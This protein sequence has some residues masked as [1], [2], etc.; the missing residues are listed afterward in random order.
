ME[1]CWR[2]RKEISRC[3]EK[4]PQNNKTKQQNNQT[5][6]TTKKKKTK[7]LK[8][9]IYQQIL[10][11]FFS[12]HK[13]LETDNSLLT[14]TFRGCQAG[15]CALALMTVR[16]SSLC[17]KRQKTLL[18]E[19]NMFYTRNKKSRA[20]DPTVTMSFKHQQQWFGI[21]NWG[22]ASTR[23]SQAWYKVRTE[24]LFS[25]QERS[26]DKNWRLGN[27]STLWACVMCYLLSR[28]AEG[29]KGSMV[30]ALHW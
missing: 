11:Y 25:I 26:T 10:G 21:I 8:K 6:S 27:L 9:L 22:K 2:G 23:N 5:H 30:D 17:E 12:Q 20:R 24:K 1:K 16:T 13:A 15:H 29:G 28:W 14:Y 18:K 19:S 3:G 7:E 4:N